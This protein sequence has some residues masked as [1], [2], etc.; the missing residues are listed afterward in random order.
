ML[1]LDSLDEVQPSIR[2]AVVEQ[3]REMATG[4]PKCGIVV[5]CRT[6]DYEPISDS[7]Y[8]V[9]IA[10]LTEPA[11]HT[12]VNAWFKHE[13]TKAKDLL[14]V[15]AAERIDPNMEWIETS[16]PRY[17]AADRAENRPTAQTPSSPEARRERSVA[18]R[19]TTSIKFAVHTV[20]S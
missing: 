12:I 1:V 7:F 11:I 15:C 19:D 18:L 9:E 17:V 5:S 4:Y 10:R 20:P 13:R 14:G 3:V 16:Q 2:K 8:E 6:A